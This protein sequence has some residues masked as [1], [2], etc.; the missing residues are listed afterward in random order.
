MKKRT[1][2]YRPKPVARPVC[3][4]MRDELI[5]PAQ[6][7]VSVLAT[8]ADAEAVESARHALATAYNYIGLACERRGRPETP[9][10]I[11]G[12]QALQALVDRGDRLGVYRGTGRS[13]K[14]CARRSRHAT[15]RFRC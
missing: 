6:L 1:K 12:M 8:S 3:K 9:T 14:R 11:A 2:K 10:I 7:A 5:L 4:G 15:R 13:C